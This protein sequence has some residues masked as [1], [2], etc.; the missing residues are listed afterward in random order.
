MANTNN[1]VGIQENP[2]DGVSLIPRFKVRVY[3]QNSYYLGVGANPP[4]PYDGYSYGFLAAEAGATLQLEEKV[5][6]TGRVFVADSNVIGPVVED[7]A[8]DVFH[9]QQRGADVSVGIDIDTVSLSA[10]IGWGQLDAELEIDS[11]GVEQQI[12]DR[13]YKYSAG[14]VAWSPV[15]GYR[16]NYN[17]NFTE[18]GDLQHWSVSLVKQF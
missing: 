14:S 8:S 18:G 2:I 4:V 3:P 5:A 10:G 9:A 7:E 17:Q 15:S 12:V 13:N 6:M 16:L 11:S 1:R